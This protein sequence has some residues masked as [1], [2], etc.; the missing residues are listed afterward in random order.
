MSNALLNHTALKRYIVDRIKAKRSFWDCPRVSADAVQFYEAFVSSRLR[1]LV[2]KAST[3]GT[4]PADDDTPKDLLVRGAVRR[5]V[6]QTLQDQITWAKITRIDDDPLD[7]LTVELVEKID[8][9]IQYHPT[10]VK[11]FNPHPN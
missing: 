8:G 6:M 4:V 5:K 9:D 7:H 2:R 10:N 11:T 1:E 3:S